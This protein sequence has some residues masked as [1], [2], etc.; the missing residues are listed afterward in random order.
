MRRPSGGP[1]DRSEKDR[2]A[3]DRSGR[4]RAGAALRL[5][6]T[7]RNRAARMGERAHVD[8]ERLVAERTQQLAAVTSRV[9]MIL[10][11]I[12]DR[13]FAFDKDWRI[14]YVSKHGQEQ[15]R[16]LG[17]DPCGVIGK[18]L[19]D[20]FPD[21][22]TEA[23][24]RHAMK[25]RA[26]VVHEHYYPPL[27]EW[28]ENRTFP[29]ADGGLAIFQTYVTDRRKA[30]EALRRSEAYLAET[31]RLTH[32]GT[33]AWNVVTGEVFWSSETY[34]LYGVEPGETTPSPDLFFRLVH[35]D[36]RRVV[37]QAFAS[38]VRDRTDYELDFRIVRPDGATRYIHSIGHPVYDASG[39][40]AEVVGTV[41]DV[42]E[43]VLAEQERT[44][45]LRRLITSQEEERR[46]ISRE[47]HDHFG[48]QLT[49][50]TLKLAALKGD[51]RLPP[52]VHAQIE[53]LTAMVRTL[54]AD[55][56]TLVWKLRPI[57]LDDLGLAVA[58]ANFVK[59][60]SKDFGIH[61][62]LHTSGLD[63]GR[64]TGEIET[65]L[66]RVL[67]EALTNVAKHAGAGHVDVLLER[68][69]SYVSLIV[70]DDGQGYDAAAAFGAEPGG[71]GLIG[72]RE[73]VLLVGGTL[74]LE[75]QPGHGATT[76]VRIPV[77][78]A[79]GGAALS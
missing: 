67:Q 43:R 20:E 60:W 6:V 76:F 33:G 37:Q 57:A 53:S 56:D 78:R 44:L 61:A 77:P 71:L 75:S 29:T 49:A 24:F 7:E 42:T 59:T 72:M 4:R 70:E 40:V 55:V 45:L 52:D 69:A 10:D 39:E 74:E 35:P 48:Q 19:W 36:D 15:L 73:R 8:L 66:Y 62:E 28:V 9:E 12:T 2:R 5:S 34:R 68:R 30:A 65:V 17:K 64:L 50:L 54:D 41:L 21:P 26:V 27:G 51:G 16:R 22:P 11:S 58:L 32:T 25:E 13:F 47:M 23:V 46:R 31:H 79:P 38:V 18:R 63:S 1:K 3:R 14:T